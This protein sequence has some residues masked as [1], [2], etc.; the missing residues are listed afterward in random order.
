MSNLQVDVPPIAAAGSAKALVKGLAILAAVGQADEPTTLSQLVT[1]T[2]LPR[3]TTLRLLDALVDGRVLVRD[4][5]GAYRLGPQLAVWG[6]RYLKTLDLPRQAEDLMHALAAE[7]RETC[8]LGVRDAR[9]VLYVAK[10]DGSQAVRP[11]ARVGSRNPL[12]STGIGKLLLAWAEPAVVEEQI[13]A[14][15]VARTPNTITDR[16]RLL[17]ELAATRDRGYA[18]DD[19]EN[20]EGVRC[21]AVPVRDHTGEVVAAMSVAAPAYRFHLDDL[22]RLAP[23]VRTAADELS[24]RLGCPAD[25]DS[26]TIMEADG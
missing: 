5:A 14:G 6:Q 18:I 9:E 17:A 23:R 11:A 2:G 10:A 15:L 4:A 19:V 7:T 13:A 22:P 8:F 16:E 21:V 25:R 12:H 26:T 20:E 3:A 1:T 24:A